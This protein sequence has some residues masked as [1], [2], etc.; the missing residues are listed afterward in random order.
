M[1]VGPCGDVPSRPSELSKAIRA[2][3]AL[4]Q[5]L[6]TEGR[7]TPSLL[8]VKGPPCSY[9]PSVQGRPSTGLTVALFDGP[10]PFCFAPT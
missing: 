2:A 1:A 6:S 5:L 10:G 9:T 8:D 7:L 3:I 4:R